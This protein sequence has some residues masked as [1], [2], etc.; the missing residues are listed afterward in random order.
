MARTNIG[1]V[2]ADLITDNGSV[3]WSLVQGEQFEYPVTVESLPSLNE[4]YI[5]EAVVIEAF[6]RTG[7]T[8]APRE[9]LTNGAQTRLTTRLPPTRGPWSAPEA[10]Y[11]ND[12]V[13]Y[14]DKVY[15][16]LQGMGR[17]SST[18]PNQDPAWE[19]VKGGLIDVQFPRTL[20]L[21]WQLFPTVDSHV[22]GFFELRITEPPGGTF[23]STWKPV[24]GLIEIQFSP[25]EMVPD[26]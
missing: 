24:R 12:L 14:N 13:P 2:R 21:D 15:R 17:I 19:L 18:P 25:T 11:T 7:Q 20:S 3:L 9:H 4:T 22:Y 8:T 5:I 1:Q 23:Q 16:L 26:L 6:N 10:Y